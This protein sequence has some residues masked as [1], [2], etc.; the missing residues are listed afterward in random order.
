MSDPMHE[1]RT[2]T[3]QIM[4]QTGLDEVTA[5]KIAS[6]RVPPPRDSAARAIGDSLMLERVLRAPP[7]P[8]E[9]DIIPQRRDCPDCGGGGW[10]KEAV[11]YPHPNFGKLFPCRCTLE[12]KARYFKTRRFEILSKLQGELGGELSLCRLD[13]FDPSWGCDIESVKSLA[14]ALTA[15]RDFLCDPRRW[16]Y[17]YG[18]PGVGKSHLS[19]G[20]A[21]AYADS[22]MGRVAYA[23]VGALLRYVRGGYSDGSGDE[24][25]SALQVVELLVLDDLGSEYHKAGAEDDHTDSLLFELINARYNYARATVISSN[26]ELDAIEARVQSRIRGKARR[27]QVDN[28]DQR[29]RGAA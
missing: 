4:E 9:P 20:I 8:N 18:P 27:I 5:A 13:S 29:L 11:P 7:T 2:Q 14:Y 25:L 15:A 17:F 19:A 3:L 12:E 21:L 1:L 28:D 16:L 26:L 6:A 24:R 10:Y 23:S 22:G